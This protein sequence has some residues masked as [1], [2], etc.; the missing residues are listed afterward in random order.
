MP[1]DAASAP[2]VPPDRTGTDRPVA[3]VTGGASGI[4]RA[5]C[6]RLLGD[7]FR[8]AVLD[9]D[10]AEAAR[11]AG[12]DGL[13]LAADVADAGSVEQAVRAV[14]AELGRVDVL[15]NNAGITGGPAA[16]RCH[17][18]PIEEW[19]R[20]LG[21]N[22]RGP[23]LVSHA[24]LPVMLEQGAGNIINLVSIAGMVAK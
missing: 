24:V 1:A 5:S 10:G 4:G 11:V 13:G 20:V 19:D 7:G 3:V 22:L 23:F 9:L 15:F 6:A 14:V 12:P 17:E 2:S 18:T 21:V 16:T 8:L